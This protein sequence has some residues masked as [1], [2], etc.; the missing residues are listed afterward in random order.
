LAISRE[1]KEQM[2]AEYADRL[3]R[4]Q[5]MILADY[6]GLTVAGISELRTRLREV[7]GTFQVVKNSLFERALQEAGISVPADALQGPVAVGYCLKEVPPVAKALV[8][9]AKETEFLQIRGAI[10]GSGFVNQ[11]RVLALAELPPREVLLAQLLGAVQG[12]MSSL[13]S[14]ITAPLREIAQVLRARSEQG[15]EAGAEAATA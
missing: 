3:S 7:D 1:K 5:A 6:R 13:A 8:A 14:T 4:S 10:L 12:P 15:Q 2:V 11:A 9:Y